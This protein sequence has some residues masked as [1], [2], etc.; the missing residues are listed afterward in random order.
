MLF[1]DFMTKNELLK[2]V[3]RDRGRS[4][5][6]YGEGEIHVY[7]KRYAVI[8]VVCDV[9]LMFTMSCYVAFSLKTKGKSLCI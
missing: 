4:S 2:H 5:F 3:F 8:H 1:H 9:F 6:D 7:K